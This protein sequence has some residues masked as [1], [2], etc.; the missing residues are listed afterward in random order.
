MYAFVTLLSP[1]ER[2]VLFL[3]GLPWCMCKD[4]GDFL[5]CGCWC[6]FCW[7]LREYVGVYDNVWLCAFMWLCDY[8]FVYTCV[9]VFYLCVCVSACLHVN[10]ETANVYIH[11]CVCVCRNCMCVCMCLCLCHRCVSVF[12]Y[13]CLYIRKYL[14]DMTS[15]CTNHI[16]SVTSKTQR[17][18]VYTH[19][20]LVYYHLYASW[21]RCKRSLVWIYHVDD[22][23]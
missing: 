20:S 9:S 21:V 11:L 6:W 7:I 13:V 2:K 19:R 22:L 23:I 15:F 14:K 10:V 5:L 18:L 3:K 8:V 16:R 17:T 1:W 4:V 12:V